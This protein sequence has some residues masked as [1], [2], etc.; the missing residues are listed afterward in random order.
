MDTSK[1]K[2][3]LSRD[4]RH[5]IFKRHRISHTECEI[6]SVIKKHGCDLCMEGRLNSDALSFSQLCEESNLNFF[7]QLKQ[8]LLY[9]A[10]NTFLQK[11]SNDHRK[12]INSFG[13]VYAV[14][15]AIR[16]LGVGYRVDAGVVMLAARMLN[17][18]TNYNVMDCIETNVKIAHFEYV[19]P[20]L[21]R[22]WLLM[23][24]NLCYNKNSDARKHAAK[25]VL[26][27][28]QLEFVPRD[29]CKIVYLDYLDLP[30]T[31]SLDEYRIVA[32][33]FARNLSF[34]PMYQTDC[35]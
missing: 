11:E 26:H 27:A 14:E 16:K 31:P 35:S 1:T 28:L 13:L 32:A 7:W 17:L 18:D 33:E 29:V 9:I 25:A 20:A 22:M 5:R 3:P 2:R 6:A 21:G 34:V 30:E 4:S 24:L 19:P 10:K 23:D 8:T 15:N 12:T